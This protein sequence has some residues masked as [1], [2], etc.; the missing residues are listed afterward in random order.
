MKKKIINILFILGFLF[1]IIF[2][3]W[4]IVF[5][6]VSPL[7]LLSSNRYCS[8][9]L[10]LIPFYD[11]FNGNY[12]RLDIFG[13]I[14]LFIP[15]GIYINMFGK[16]SKVSKSIYKIIIISLIFEVSQYVFGIGASDITDII[17]NTI[18][19]VI[20]IVI[21]MAIKKIFKD[22]NKVKTFITICSMVVMIPV[23]IILIGI[24]M[25]N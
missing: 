2:I 13:N 1:Y 20:G 10:N 15:L 19:G 25:Y 16:N 18:G 8:R 23:V 6:Y 24:F 12:N 17:T 21:Y 14:I 22:D 11:I 5:K 9:T 3:L 4:N 7:E